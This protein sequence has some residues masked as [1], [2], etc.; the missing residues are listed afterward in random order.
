MKKILGTIKAYIIIT[1]GLLCYVLGWTIFLIPNNLVGGGVSGISSIIL[2]AFGVPI[3]VTYFAINIILL[4]IALKV[5]GKGFGV[6]TVYAI[7]AAT[8]FFQFVPAFIPQDFIEEIAISNGKLLSAIFGGVLSGLGIGISFSQGGSTGGTDIVALMVAKYHN[9]APGRMILYMDLVI[10]ACSLLIPAKDIT[11][12]AGNVIGKETW[13]MRLAT[14]L[15]GYMLIASC[16]QIVD[17]MVAGSRQSVQVY[18]FSREYE[19]IADIITKEMGRGVT[20]LTGEGWY[21]KQEN[22]MLMVLIHKTE[23]S[24]I[25]NLIKDIDR[26]AFISMAPVTGVWGRGFQ[27]IGK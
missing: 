1:L 27:Q 20:V 9:I 7:V 25:H 4:L 23:T 10:I 24:K 3:S 22:K 16:S 14:V 19:K 11:D 8:L 12:A 2:Y 18:I 6:K 17:M 15:Y 21:T 13:G 5:L 26:D